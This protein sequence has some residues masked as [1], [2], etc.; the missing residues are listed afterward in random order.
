MVFH[1]RFVTT[2]LLTAVIADGFIGDFFPV[3]RGIRQGDPLS[4]HLFLLF[5]E[6]M[7]KSMIRH[8]FIHGVFLPGSKGF[9]G[10]YFAWADDVTLSLSGTYFKGFRIAR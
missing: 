10:K 7:L 3:I 4:F 5:L 1:V 9:N 2:F 8:D 6:S